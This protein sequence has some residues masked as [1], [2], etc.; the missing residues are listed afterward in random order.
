MKIMISISL[1]FSF[2]VNCLMEEDEH[3]DERKKE[4]KKDRRKF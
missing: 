4:R 1:G 2:L 3:N